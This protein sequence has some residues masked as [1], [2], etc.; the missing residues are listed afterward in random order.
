M[1][2]EVRCCAICAW[3]CNISA[4][5][6][7]YTIVMPSCKYE[8]IKLKILIVQQLGDLLDKYWLVAE[9]AVT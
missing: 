4:S 7:S 5:L 8:F 2:G 3:K 9:I 6:T 1:M